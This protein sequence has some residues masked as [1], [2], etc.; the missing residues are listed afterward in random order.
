M[1]NDDIDR[2]ARADRK[3]LRAARKRHRDLVAR[4]LFRQQLRAEMIRAV[5]SCTGLCVV[6][7]HIEALH[8]NSS[9][10]FEAKPRTPGE[11]HSIVLGWLLSEADQADQGEHPAL[12]K[13]R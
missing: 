4:Q 13:L 6:C 12:A 2:A 8:V 5:E 10:A 11:L 7:D 9:H 3:R 1:K